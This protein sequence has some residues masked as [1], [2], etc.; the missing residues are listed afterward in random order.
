MSVCVRVQCVKQGYLT[1]CTH[2]ISGSLTAMFP[3]R[4]TTQAGVSGVASSKAITAST[5]ILLA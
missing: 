1:T 5:P 2:S 4:L 3:E